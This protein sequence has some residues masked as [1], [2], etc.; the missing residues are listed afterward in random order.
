MILVKWWV[1]G[2]I[3]NSKVWCNCLFLFY[4]VIFIYLVVKEKLKLCKFING[5]SD[6]SG[7][8]KFCCNFYKVYI[9]VII[10]DIL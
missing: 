5:M 9:I 3:K 6:C 10:W 8:V 1:F 2:W 7:E 4:L